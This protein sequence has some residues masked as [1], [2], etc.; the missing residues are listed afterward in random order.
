MTKVKAPQ[1]ASND[2]VLL[3]HPYVALADVSIGPHVF[4][5]IFDIIAIHVNNANIYQRYLKVNETS[6]YNI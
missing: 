2:M 5:P 3:L 6:N 1:L 4:Q